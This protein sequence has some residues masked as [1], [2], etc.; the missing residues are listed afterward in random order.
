MTTSS[1]SSLPH[2]SPP[3]RIRTTPTMMLRYR[4]YLE[5]RRYSYGSID[6]LLWGA[7]RLIA[8]FP[9]GVVPLDSAQLTQETDSWVTSPATQRTYRRIAYRFHEFLESEVKAGEVVP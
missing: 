5:H 6:Y 7:G 9:G 3:L 8:A 4:A 1:S 2:R